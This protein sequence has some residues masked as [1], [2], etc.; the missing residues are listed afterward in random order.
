MGDP[1]NIVLTGEL[2]TLKRVSY[3][4]TTPDACHLYIEH[5]GQDYIGTLLIQDVGFC[6]HIYCVLQY[7]TRR[8]I[9]EIGSLPMD[10]TL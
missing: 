7:H 10:Y 3:S 8:S 9:K 5:Q 2:G 4:A 1:K 6:W